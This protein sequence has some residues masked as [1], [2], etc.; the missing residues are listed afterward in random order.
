MLMLGSLEGEGEGQ[1]VWHQPF[2]QPETISR[3]TSRCP[4]TVQGKKKGKERNPTPFW[5]LFFRRKRVHPADAAFCSEE[6]EGFQRAGGRSW[7]QI[8]SMMMLS[9]R[10]CFSLYGKLEKRD[11]LS[12][13]Y[14]IQ[15]SYFLFSAKNDPLGLEK[16]P[17]GLNRRDDI[18]TKQLSVPIRT[19]VFSR[20]LVFIKENVTL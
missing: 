12:H 3:Q 8:S 6:S 19:F 18:N 16:K 13:V 14:K 9:S 7:S 4:I 2:V 1:S 20:T 15:G 5:V 10:F 17:S 11:R